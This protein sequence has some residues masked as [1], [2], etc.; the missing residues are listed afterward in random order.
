MVRQGKFKLELVRAD[1]SIPFQEHMHNTS[2][3]VYA[4]VEPDTE[5]FIKFTTDDP[6]NII[7]AA[8]V[9]GN[10]LGYSFTLKGG[11]ADKKF[12]VWSI[13]HHKALKFDKLYRR[14]NKAPTEVIKGDSDSGH[15]TGNIEIKVY[16]YILLP[17]YHTQGT[18]ESNWQSN[19]EAILKGLDLSSNKKACSSARGK[20]KTEKT[21]N[22]TGKTNNYNYGAKLATIKLNY[23]STVG[24][25]AAKILQ[26]APMPEFHGAILNDANYSSEEDV[27]VEST[28]KRRRE[29]DDVKPEIPRA[30]PRTGTDEVIDLNADVKPETSRAK[31]RSGTDEI[32]DLN[33]DVDVVDCAKI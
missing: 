2:G 25:I 13:D 5:Y 4:E 8:S 18:F 29:N 30:K 11:H 1:S 23:C 22:V 32:I 26:P 24:L 9:D 19:S 17:G 15:W 33:D 14:R 21:K 6:R 3:E 31:P 28:H 16:E 20:T 7:I 10:K 12:G 27:A